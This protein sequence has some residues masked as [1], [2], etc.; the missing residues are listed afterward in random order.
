MQIRVQ[1]SLLYT[2]RYIWSRF[3]CLDTLYFIHCTPTKY[4]GLYT[5]S[6]FNI[7]MYIHWFNS[8]TWIY[9]CIV[10]LLCMFDPVICS[11]LL[12]THT[13]F[14]GSTRRVCKGRYLGYH[15][16]ASIPTKMTNRRTH[17]W[18]D[19]RPY[20]FLPTSPRWPDQAGE[21]EGEGRIGRRYWNKVYNPL[22]KCDST[23]KCGKTSILKLSREKNM[24]RNIQWLFIRI[25]GFLIQAI[26]LNLIL[27]ARCTTAILTEL[28]SNTDPQLLIPDWLDRGYLLTRAQFNNL[29]VAANA[30]QEAGP[31][32]WAT[33][34]ILIQLTG[35]PC[36][37]THA[38]THINADINTL[39]YM[40]TCASHISW[41]CILDQSPTWPYRL[42][43]CP[44]W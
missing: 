41:Q 33:D 31:W 18:Q 3:L 4:L 39:W 35:A 22:Q 43:Q 40:P 36:W 14:K 17:N 10:Q 42:D 12:P 20:S 38:D 9:N 44:T 15:R 16:C 11:G 23:S 24:N 28:H 25:W 21:E 19:S 5:L 37:N 1:F 13:C 6:D 30:V 27:N 34:R 7:F 2:H 32:P 29:A 8:Y 26:Y